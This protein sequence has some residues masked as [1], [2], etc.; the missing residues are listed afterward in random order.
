MKDK[1]LPFYRIILRRRAGTPLPRADL[2]RGFAFTAYRDGMSGPGE[3]LKPLSRTSQSRKRPRNTS[4]RNLP[5]IPM[6]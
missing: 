4:K 1:S 6:K 5:V 2:P 3:K